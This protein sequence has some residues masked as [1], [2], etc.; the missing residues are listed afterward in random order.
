MVSRHSFFYDGGF[1]HTSIVPFSKENKKQKNV[2]DFK[3]GRLGMNGIES[4]VE[5]VGGIKTRARQ[6]HFLVL[7]PSDS[8]RQWETAGD[9][10]GLG[11]EIES[12]LKLQ[13]R[14]SYCNSTKSFAHPLRSTGWFKQTSTRSKNLCRIYN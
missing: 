11:A 14:G 6:S 9:E 12:R 7:M 10:I 8:D 3:Q 4:W 2:G 5:S 13:T 1:N